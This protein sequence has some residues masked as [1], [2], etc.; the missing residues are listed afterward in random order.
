VVGLAAAVLLGVGPGEPVAPPRTAADPPVEPV[1]TV[2]VHGRPG[3]FG[4][5]GETLP[6]GQSLALRP[7]PG[8]GFPAGVQAGATAVAGDGT[9]FV[10]GADQLGGTG[11]ATSRASVIGA[12]GSG[13]FTTIRLATT[14]GREELADG[15]GR[16]LAPPV[17]D[18]APIAGG[19]A[20]AFTVGHSYQ[21]HDPAA[22]GA[23]PVLGILSKVDGAWRVVDQWSGG[24][25]RASAPPES[26]RAGE[27]GAG[28]RALNER[29]CPELARATGHSD[30]RGFG[31]L[32][33]LPSSGDLVVAQA[34]G[35]VAIRVARPD[36]GGRFTAA[37]TG[38]YRYPAIQD[39]Q[40]GDDVDLVLRDLHADPTGERGDERFVVGLRDRGDEE[41]VR[42]LVIQEF[43]Y[44]AAAGTIVPVSAPTIPGDQASEDGPFF[45]YSAAVY[46][47]AGNL[48]AARHQW[49]AGGKLA[50]YR[51][52]E[53]GRKL[54][55]PDC[56]YDPA[57]PISSY[58]TTV[59]DRTV[60][61]RG[62][63]PDYDLFQAKDLPVIVGMMVEPAGDGIVG[64]TLNGAL[65]PV[66]ASY[67]D[68]IGF[69]IGNVVDAA[70]RLLPRAGGDVLQQHPGAF[71][72]NGHLWLAAAHARPTEPATVVDQWLYEVDVHDL[73]TPP[74]VRLSDVPGHVAT[75]PAGHTVTIGT[76]ESAG[77]W[78][79]VDVDSRAYVRVCTD[80]AASVD[81]S[82]DGVPGNGFVLSHRSGFG[83][84][85][86]EVDYRVEVP[87]AGRY[88]VTYR[89]S[90]F[91]VTTEAEIV[92][93]VTG[94]SYETAVSTDGGWRT[95]NQAELITLPAGVST[96]RLSAVE[97]HGGWYLSWFSLQRA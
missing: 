32:V 5:L 27:P 11:T 20:V 47:R 91:E 13:T 35:L 76:T 84:L 94:R 67:Q 17:A 61:G 46:D 74:P 95:I 49:L 54:G 93:S 88:R 56:P 45:G 28:A 92:L 6:S 97:G 66:R 85:S 55:G 4:S 18:L 53:G 15:D 10:A 90:T 78:A 7:V 34:D 19:A 80:A 57:A 44:D 30:C 24:R 72:A 50:I 36:A 68:G 70:L 81:C 31:E 77:S 96:I 8:W 73:F 63:R 43:R 3:S 87:V 79:T 89:V 33:S 2:A 71:D 52:A 86:G 41:G 64:L 21:G 58:L 22:H 69:Q 1:A 37:I 26:E 62:C 40:T 29:A 25:L 65:L 9:V 82:Y 38:H 60:W 48:W 39:P 51:N 42:P 12:Y 75:I 23:W 83:H 59:G 14:A 16:P